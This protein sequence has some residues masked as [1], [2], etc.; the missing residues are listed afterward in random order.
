M[1]A[2]RPLTPGTRRRAATAL[3][4]VLAL[5]VAP[6][7]VLGVA[8][9]AQ[10]AVIRPFN[11]VFSVNT[12]GDVMLIGNTLM[13]CAASTACTTAQEIV[14]GPANANSN[15]NFAPRRVDVD[16]DATT[17]N[18]ST[19]DLDIPSG[20][21][22]LFAALVWGGRT[23]NAVGTANANPDLRGTARLTVKP[24][25]GP[26]QTHE[27]TTETV[28][29]SNEHYAS[30]LDV[31]NIVAGAG[32]ATYTVANVQSDARATIN[33]SPAN[34]RYAGW[35]LVVAVADPSA[36][37]RNLTIFNGYG[38]VSTG[39]AEPT[40]FTVDGFLTPPSGPVRTTLG[41]V[42]F[43]GDMGLQGD[44]LRLNNKVIS[45]DRN[46]ETNPWNSTITN[47]GKDLGQSLA[48]RNPAYANQ[49]GIDVDLIDVPETARLANSASSATIA[50]STS[51][52]TYLPAFVTFATDLYDPKL[53][54]TK[55]VTDLTSTGPTDLDVRPND[56]LEYRVPVENIG[57]D[58]SSRSRFFDAIPTGTSYLPG[59][60]TLDGVPQTDAVDGDTTQFVADQNG[61]V[62]I[63]L[64][65]GATPT[66][67][68]EIPMSTGAAQHVVTFRVTV[69]GD[70][71]NGQE[72]TNAAVLTYRGKTTNASA[73]SATNAVIRP[74]VTAPIDGNSPPEATPHVLTFEP[75]PTARTI[76]IAVLAGD[77]DP[78]GDA[79]GV[80]AVTDAAG[81]TVTINPNG[82]V[83]YAPRDDF[84]GRDVFTYTIE[85]TAGNRS[86]ATVQIEVLNTAP[87]AVDDATTVPGAT[88]A[89]LAL[90]ANDTDAN[91]DTLT[92]KSAGPT[93]AQG[94]TV[95]V[96]NGVATYTPLPGFR[97]NDTFTYVVEDS[98]GGSDTATVT[99]T[100]TNNAPVAVDDTYAT[101]AGSPVT[102]AVRGNDTDLDGDALSV[103]VLAGPT[104]G[105]LTL[106]PNGTGTYTPTTGWSGTDTFTYRVT[107][108]HGGSDTATVTITV[109]GAP[110]ADDDSASTPSGTAVDVPVLVGDTDPN[111]D[112]LSVA[113][114][115]QPSHGATVVQVDGTV[116]YTPAAGW[117]GVD[118]FTY[119]LSDGRGL[120]DTATVTVTT[121]NAAPVANADATST[122]TNTPASRVDVHS[123]DTDVNVTAGVPG[124]V[125]T[126]TGATADNGASVVVES[127]GTLT[128]TPA[129]GFS[130]VVTVSYTLSDGA[131]GTATGTLTVTVDNGAPSAGS[132]GPVSTPTN[133]SVLI[134]VL[135]NDTDPNTGDTLTITPGSLTDPVDGTG[136]TRGDVE[137]VA[138][139]VRYTPPTGWSGTVT[140]TY[141]VSDG[142][143]GTATGT[144]TV[145]VENAAPVAVDD[146]ITTPSGTAVTV[147]V[148]ADD[149]DANIPGTD[150]VLTVVGAVA[151]NG[152]SVVVETDGTLTVTPAAGFEGVV[153]VRYT[154]GDGAGGTDEGQLLVTVANAAPV[155]VA[156]GASTPY[157]TPVDVDLLAN[158]TDAN[159]GD[160]LAVVPGSTT[161]P[162]DADGTPRGTVTVTDGVATYTPPAGFSGVVTFDYTVTDG[163]DQRVATVTITV[164]NAPPVPTTDTVR[165]PA[166]SPVVIDVV[167]NDA[168][169]DG[170]T[171]TI[172]GVTQPAS[173]TVTIVDGRLVYTPVAGFS[174]TVTFTY[175]VSDGQGGTAT[176]T[177]TID[178]VAAPPAA[179]AGVAGAATGALPRTGVEVGTAAGVAALLLLLGGAL[180]LG[181]RRRTA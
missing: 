127:D 115:T 66:A 160:T 109:N 22:V 33:G 164:G 2:P 39:D 105:T 68:G 93:S 73:S 101:A 40:T 138:G 67:G 166:G 74:V 89:V 173:G 30:Y 153:T 13:T 163:T 27:L 29:S 144:V 23:P 167:G 129:T 71:T 179:A 177:V 59:S 130:G 63:H 34:D 42:T 111:G 17:F 131:T 151:D 16:S 168:D 140:F 125:L 104:H 87:E 113:S 86:T 36:P 7:V 55:T 103:S 150:Q 65:A 26:A 57:L 45:D 147:D 46:V 107:D 8:A 157:G 75:A 41:V 31:T 139:E 148:L 119:V 128:V 12:N 92:V 178:V 72:L 94:G 49:L 19:A 85:D 53:L 14:N 79:L 98:R 1:F 141:E 24:Q 4:T 135:D 114:V 117:A 120:T 6:L 77:T 118:T 21:A 38:N 18:S 161:D 20:G 78:E 108:A 56:V 11:P 10:A 62:L 122:P 83:T 124:Q 5:I 159:P 25:G 134:D 9:P 152:A 81:G 96:T 88:P 142:D 169:P 112:T 95:T 54:G 91:G 137:I 37:A 170:G 32:D 158:D 52:D 143:G 100:V 145:V 154:V 90:T 60:V 136:T 180:V 64:G 181:A 82:T 155:A 132:D 76:D 61:H 97:G 121:L 133:T 69:D 51:G 165:T 175:T 171:L 123:N 99:V 70:A 174:G 48:P 172:T 116:R 110:V 102:L 35:S 28:D 3:S 50:L 146:A 15:N 149:T 43:E 44:S 156:D 80:V 58:T 126:V 84:A 47:R 176:T 162:V 106:N